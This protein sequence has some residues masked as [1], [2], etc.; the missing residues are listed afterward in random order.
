MIPEFTYK[1]RNIEASI[2]GKSLEAEIQETDPIRRIRKEKE[3]L[4][5][6]YN[7]PIERIF[8]LE[9]VHGNDVIRITEKDIERNKDTFYQKADGM[10]T[11][12]ENI[13]LCIRTADCLPLF[14]HTSSH[15]N[16]K[17]TGIAHIGW[18][19]LHRGITQNIISMILFTIQKTIYE[20][21]IQKKPVD[22]DYFPLTIF[23]GIYIP[24]SIYE[25]GKEVADLFPIVNLNQNRYYLDLWKNT[26][27]VLKNLKDH[28]KFD[29]QDPFSYI[30]SNQ[31]EVF[32]NFYS[33]RRKDSYRNLNVIF[34]RENGNL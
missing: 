14:I 19:G 26:V 32:R 17:I 1:N 22:F 23:P 34:L 28:M 20:L 25:V 27:Y 4:A 2:F 15:I 9:Q 33:H 10:I 11:D 6:Y 13:L 7:L 5:D 12:R 24:G 3:F 8:F 29:L 31:N 16:H 18:R 30:S 21:K